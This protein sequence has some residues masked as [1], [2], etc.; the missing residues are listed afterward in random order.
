M[1]I[2]KYDTFV[3][4]HPLLFLLDDSIKQKQ[5]FVIGLAVFDKDRCLPFAKDESCIVCEEHCPTYDK[6]I[7][8]KSIRL[9]IRMEV[10]LL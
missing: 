5:R 8:F 1:T 2:S 3:C 7:K 6:A 10:K 9:K 4:S